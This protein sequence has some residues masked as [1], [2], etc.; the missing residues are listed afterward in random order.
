MGLWVY[1]LVMQRSCMNTDFNLLSSHLG[2][3]AAG[4]QDITFIDMYD[5]EA[6]FEMLGEQDGETHFFYVLFIQDGDGIWRLR[7]F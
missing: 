3:I 4:I 5:G 1:F 2:G 7:F 6:E